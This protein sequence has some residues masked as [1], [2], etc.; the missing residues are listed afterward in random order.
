MC[1]IIPRRSRVRNANINCD[2]FA[3]IAHT[4]SYQPT[5]SVTNLSTTP[6]LRTPTHQTTGCGSSIILFVGFLVLLM[7]FPI[8]HYLPN[9]EV[10]ITTD[11]GG[12]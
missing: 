5:S 9:D 1:K 4:Y 3:R 8:E 2:I 7:G 6:T 10:I 12:H 11:H